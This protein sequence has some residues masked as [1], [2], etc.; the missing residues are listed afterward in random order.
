MTCARSR[1]LRRRSST[2]STGGLDLLL[3]KRFMDLVTSSP[4]AA[5]RKISI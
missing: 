2:S 1:T 5:E 3:M 4:R